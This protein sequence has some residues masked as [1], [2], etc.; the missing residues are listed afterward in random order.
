MIS[1]PDLLCFESMAE[2]LVSL[3]SARVG[4]PQTKIK[5]LKQN[6]LCFSRESHKRPQ[7]GD[8]N[9]KYQGYQIYFLKPSASSASQTVFDLPFVPF[10]VVAQR[11]SIEER[12]NE[13]VFF[14]ATRMQ[15]V[16]LTEFWMHNYGKTPDQKQLKWLSEMTH[17]DQEGVLR[18]FAYRNSKSYRQRAMV[19]ENVKTNKLRQWILAWSQQSPYE[20]S[21]GDSDDDDENVGLSQKKPLQ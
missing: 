13:K 8:S 16:F 4:Q 20:D 7:R 15:S 12:K 18:W 17:L 2:I 1:P 11:V 6:S 19:Q 21:D 3:E 14:C 9:M 5:S 10:H